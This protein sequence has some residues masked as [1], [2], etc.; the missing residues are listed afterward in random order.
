MKKEIIIY[1]LWHAIIKK[2]DCWEIF[3]IKDIL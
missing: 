3:E 2:Y 1:I